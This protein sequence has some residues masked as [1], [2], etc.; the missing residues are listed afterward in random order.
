[1][2]RSLLK[3]GG[4][5]LLDKCLQLTCVPTSTLKG[6][7]DTLIAAETEVAG[8]NGKFVIITTGANYE[9]DSPAAGA[10]VHGKIKTCMV[11]DVNSTYK[12]VCWIWAFAD[13]NG[14]LYSA[15]GI[16][17]G[18]YTGT[19]A[20]GNSCECGSTAT[21]FEWADGAGDGYHNM[22]IAIDNPASGYCDVIV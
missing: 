11:D 16:V 13:D 21:F 19:L 22:V 17:Q 14:N 3:K 5:Q 10:A 6:E 8:L 18:Q 1:M 4:G 2:S 15:N 20:L 9:V 12:L 7:L